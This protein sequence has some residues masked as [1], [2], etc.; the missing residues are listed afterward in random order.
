MLASNLETLKSLAVHSNRTEQKELVI[1]MYE[2]RTILLFNSAKLMLERWARRVTFSKADKAYAKYKLQHELKQNP[3]PLATDVQKEATE[4]NKQT[5]RHVQDL[6]AIEVHET[7][8]RP[9]SNTS[10]E[11]LTFTAKRSC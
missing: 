11:Q 5:T 1:Q 6:Q 3:K 8:M 10:N 2:A 4:K 9:T 7:N